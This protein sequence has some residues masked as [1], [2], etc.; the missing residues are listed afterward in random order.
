MARDRLPRVAG[1]DARCRVLAASTPSLPRS[2]ASRQLDN[3]QD[4][5]RRS[6]STGGSRYGRSAWPLLSPSPARC[7]RSRSRTT[8]RA[9]LR[10]G[11]GG[12][13]VVA[14]LIPLWASYLVKV[15]TWRTIL[16]ENGVLN[17]AARA[18]RA[19]RPRILAGRHLARVHVPLASVHDPPHLRR[20]RADPGIAARGIGGSRRASG[21]AHSFGSSCRS[22]SRRSSRAR[23]SRSRSPS[24]TTSRPRSSRASSSSAT[25]IYDNIGVANNLPFAAAYAIVPDRVMIVYLCVRE[26]ARSVREPLMVEGRGHTLVPAGRDGARARVHLLPARHHH[27]STRSTRTSR[28]P[29]R[30]RTGRPSGSRVAFHDQDVRDAFW[31]SVKAAL[32]ATRVALVL[33]NARSHSRCRAIASSGGRRSRSSWC[34]R[35]RS[36]ES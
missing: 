19:R 16:A 9:S 4:A 27:A 7:S 34:C 11:C 36:R 21:S 12:I 30:S 23:S 22:P 26:A 24:A 5:R 25:S 32:V 33:G 31:L 15:Y 1:G 20:A 13:L 35:S 17:W 28:R 14:V 29:G 2:S 3:F 18:V 6:P 8:W 10:G